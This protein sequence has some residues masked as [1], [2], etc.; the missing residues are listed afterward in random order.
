MVNLSTRIHFTT[1]DG[2]VHFMSSSSVMRKI[3]NI[4]T[5]GKPNT[6]QNIELGRPKCDSDPVASVF[7]AVHFRERARA[8]VRTHTQ[9]HG[10]HDI[11]GRSLSYSFSL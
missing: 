10:R 6:R 4:S 5:T 2:N 11:K 9:T 7:S 8:L 3:V 1:R